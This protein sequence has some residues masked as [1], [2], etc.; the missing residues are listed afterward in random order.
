MKILITNDDGQTEGLQVLLAAA[1]KFGEAYAI[2]PNRQRSAIL[3]LQLIQRNL[4]HQT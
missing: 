3:C 2:V 4:T 1:K